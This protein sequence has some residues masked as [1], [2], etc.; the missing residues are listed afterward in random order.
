MRTKKTK[1]PRKDKRAKIVCGTP[2]NI[3]EAY[4]EVDYDMQ[5]VWTHAGFWALPRK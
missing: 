2:D 5:V 4:R 3:Q 1:N